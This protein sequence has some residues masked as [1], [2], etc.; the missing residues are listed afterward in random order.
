M[1]TRNKAAETIIQD[2]GEAA[3]EA[4]VVGGSLEDIWDDNTR[5]LVLEFLLEY[6]FAS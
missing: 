2:S 1:T 3:L 5:Y 6:Y 4:I